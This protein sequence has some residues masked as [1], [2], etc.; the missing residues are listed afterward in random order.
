MISDPITIDHPGLPE[1]WP[2]MTRDQVDLVLTQD[3]RRCAGVPTSWWG[4]DHEI[5]AVTKSTQV[6]AAAADE[7]AR[8]DTG[9]GYLAQVQTGAAVVG[10]ITA[11]LVGWPGSDHIDW[12]TATPD[13]PYTV[14]LCVVRPAH[15]V[16]VAVGR[17]TAV[18]DVA[19]DV[20][21]RLRTLD[22]GG[23]S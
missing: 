15:P 8:W 11:M 1:L 9:L 22:A 19:A 2:P 7:L 3:M 16:D 17:R 10:P 13:A 5:V 14:D 12:V 18:V 21:Q 6:A 23:D 4:E 20:A